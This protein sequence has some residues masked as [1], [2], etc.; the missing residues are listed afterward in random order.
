MYVFNLRDNIWHQYSQECVVDINIG[1]LSSQEG[2][3]ENLDLLSLNTLGTTAKLIARLQ[4]EKS[5]NGFKPFSHGAVAALLVLA[6]KLGCR[7]H[8]Q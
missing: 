4:N 3:M 2:L 5:Q 1:I 6:K 7:I 8:Y